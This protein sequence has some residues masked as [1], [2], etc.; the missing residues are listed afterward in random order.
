MGVGSSSRP[1]VLPS[2]RSCSLAAP[3]M[4]SLKRLCSL[5]RPAM[6]ILSTQFGVHIICTYLFTVIRA[7]EFKTLRGGHAESSS[8]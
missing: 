3:S 1:E 7:T 2:A 8:I 4:L 5:S 6:A